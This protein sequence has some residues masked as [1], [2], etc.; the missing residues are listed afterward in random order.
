MPNQHHPDKEVLGFYLDRRLAQKLRRAARTRSIPITEYLK[1]V[2]TNAT[3]NIELTEA[4]RREIADRKA[5]KLCRPFTRKTRPKA[6][7]G[8]KD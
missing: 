3:S 1:E 2:L 6:T 5:R 8:R 4:D 7:Q